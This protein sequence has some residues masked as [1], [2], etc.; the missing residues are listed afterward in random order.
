MLSPFE[1]L[2]LLNQY[3]I[4][5]II[6]PTNAKQ[7]DRDAEACEL[8]TPERLERLFDDS[9][10][11]DPTPTFRNERSRPRLRLVGKDA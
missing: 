9:I 8:G 4:L 3:R 1:R 7:H 5:E 6:D 11:L 10:D 2:S